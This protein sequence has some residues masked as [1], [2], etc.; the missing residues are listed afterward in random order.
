MQI[1]FDCLGIDNWICQ[2]FH[3]F[4]YY[5]IL[6]EY[7]NLKL[8]LCEYLNVK[9][10]LSGY[11]NVKLM[12]MLDKTVYEKKNNSLKMQILK[13]IKKKRIHFRTY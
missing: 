12:R 10:I 7:L 2:V 11:L 3:N 13:F 8:I 1:N 6:N 9:L 5:L 4:L